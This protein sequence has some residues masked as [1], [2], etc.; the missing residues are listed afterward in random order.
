MSEN[1][2]QY[3]VSATKFSCT[4]LFSHFRVSLAPPLPFDPLACLLLSCDFWRRFG[5]T[6]ACLT[7]IL[8]VSSTFVPNVVQISS[9]PNAVPSLDPNLY[10][11]R[12]SSC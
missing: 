9:I 8:R 4:Q 12:D 5:C 3:A 10:L 6:I 1:G 7:F 11:N 2:H